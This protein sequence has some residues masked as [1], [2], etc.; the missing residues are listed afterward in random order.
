MMR[1]FFLIALQF[2]FTSLAAKPIEIVMWHSLAGH[3]GEEIKQLVAD[4]NLSQQDYA[5]KLVYKGEYIESLTSF[6][7]AFRAKQPPAIVQ[8][9]EVGT[10]TMLYPRGIIKPVDELMQEQG[11]SLPKENFLPAV[12]AFYSESNRL[13]AMPFNTSIPVIFYNA[14]AVMKA[15]YSANSFPRTW[16]EM[17]V[18]ASKLRKAGYSCAYT[19][20]Y[21]AWIQI[22]S[23]S[24]I[25]G[26]PMI[27]EAHAHAIYNN[28]AI[29]NHLERLKKWQ[30]KHYFEFGGRASDATVLFTSG[31]CALFSQSSGSHNSLAELV[32]FRLGVALLPLDTQASSQRH[33]DVAGGAALWAV[34][35]LKPDIYPGIAHFFSFIAKPEVQQRWHQHTGYLPLGTSGIYALLVAQSKHPVLALAQAD[36]GNQ[37]DERVRLHVGPQNQIR[38]INDEALEAIFAGIKTP[39][40][41]IDKAVEQANY[42]LLRFIRNTRDVS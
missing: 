27:D 2:F 24:A 29:I 18:L 7:A 3:L 41:A 30:Q 21:P 19:S 35:G 6:A 23:F 40:Q 37:R 1:F 4:F 11:L 38:T 34:A 8:I 13:L 25:H 20:A 5:V 12:R 9:F 14:D 28:K 39:K 17:E 10:A 16:D 32:K 36:L 22:E 15:G 33:N 31:H 42:A 26:L